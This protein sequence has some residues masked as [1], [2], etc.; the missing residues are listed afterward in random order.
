[1]RLGVIYLLVAYKAGLGGQPHP[2]TQFTINTADLQQLRG[3]VL[4]LT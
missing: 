2:D 4:L 3:E 1:M